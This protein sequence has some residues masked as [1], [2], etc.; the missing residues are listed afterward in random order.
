[1][2][3]LL[4]DGYI[5]STGGGRRDTVILTPPLTIATEQLE[6]FLAVAPAAFRRAL[7]A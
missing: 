7:S 5:V 6:G 2:Q 1:M 4:D 3:Q